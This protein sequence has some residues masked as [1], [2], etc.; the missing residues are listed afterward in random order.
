MWSVVCGL[1]SVVCL[2]KEDDA[3]RADRGSSSSPFRW[4]PMAYQCGVWWQEKEDAGRANRGGSFFA[5]RSSFLE[6]SKLDGRVATTFALSLC[7]ATA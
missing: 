5:L 7:E 3:G 2:D 4:L 6:S 1:W